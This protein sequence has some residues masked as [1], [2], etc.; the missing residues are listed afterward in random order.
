MS[1][2]PLSWFVYG[3]AVIASGVWCHFAEPGGGEALWFGLVMGAVVLGGAVLLS[4]GRRRA[5]H[6]L[7]LTALAFVAG[8][9]T[10]EALIEHGGNREPRQ[11]FVAAWSFVQLAAAV[12]HLRKSG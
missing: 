7:A 3:F 2:Y 6:A 5:G 11:L 9:F 1:G 12:R 4:R 10:Y 8:W